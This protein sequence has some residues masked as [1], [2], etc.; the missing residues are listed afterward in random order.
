MATPAQLGNSAHAVGFLIPTELVD[1]PITSRTD[2]RLTRE[3]EQAFGYT[4]FQLTLDQMRALACDRDV[5]AGMLSD[6]EA[7]FTKD[8]GAEK[9]V[10]LVNVDGYLVRQGTLP[11]IEFSRLARERIELVCKGLAA[12]SA[13]DD[14]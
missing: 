4:V 13:L 2:L 14:Q 7:A 12:M 3:L 10:A 9:A 11:T 5:V 8:N 6:V 1:I